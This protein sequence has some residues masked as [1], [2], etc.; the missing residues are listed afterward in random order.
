MLN[1]EAAHYKEVQAAPLAEPRLKPPRPSSGEPLSEAVSSPK[2]SS[3]ARKKLLA[4]VAKIGAGAADG[5]SE[6]CYIPLRP[7]LW[8]ILRF[9]GR[10]SGY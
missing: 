10:V 4:A 3:L 9:S 1:L 8:F 5:K 6:G 7:A 2:R